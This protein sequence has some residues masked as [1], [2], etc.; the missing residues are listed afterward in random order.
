MREWQMFGLF[1]FHLV[2]NSLFNKI[3]HQ[4]GFKHWKALHVFSNMKITYKVFRLVSFSQHFNNKSIFF[5]SVYK[6]NHVKKHLLWGPFIELQL[7]PCKADFPTLR[8][9]DNS[10]PWQWLKTLQ[11]PMTDKFT[12]F[13]C[14]GGFFWYFRA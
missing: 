5:E 13:P 7:Q 2:K 14:F 12:L 1:P 9:N 8:N 10:F 4:N 11:V 3:Y 6:I